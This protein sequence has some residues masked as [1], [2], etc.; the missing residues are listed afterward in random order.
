MSLK[1][2]N[3]LISEEVIKSLMEIAI[4]QYMMM[5]NKYVEIYIILSHIIA[6]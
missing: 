1:K 3:H 2:E 5:T 6:Q 4:E